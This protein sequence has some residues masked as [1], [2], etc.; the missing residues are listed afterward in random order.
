LVIRSGKPAFKIIEKLL[1]DDLFPL[2]A[3]LEPREIRKPHIDVL[4]GLTSKT[5][6]TVAKL[7]IAKKDGDWVIEAEKSTSDDH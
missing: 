4:N 1:E 7:T 6:G 5:L 2:C 3:R